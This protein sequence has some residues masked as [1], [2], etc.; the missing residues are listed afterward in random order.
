MLT[1]LKRWWG[2]ERVEKAA[3][4]STLTS[5]L[6]PG[7]N[8]T[9]YPSI[10]GNEAV[11]HNRG[12]VYGAVRVVAQ[13]IAAQPVRVGRLA[14]RSPVKGAKAAADSP[15]WV[16][17]GTVTELDEHPLIDSLADPNP[18]LTTWGLVYL[19]VAS[20]ELAGAAFWWIDEQPDGP[21]RVWYIPPGWVTEDPDSP[22]ALTRWLIRPAGLGE[23]FR[24]DHRELIRFALPDPG[25]PLAVLGPLQAAGAAA[26]TDESIQVAQLQ[27][28]KNGIMPGLLVR[29]GKTPELNGIGGDKPALTKEQ[30][31]SLRLALKRVNGGPPG[32]GEP[33]ILDAII[34][35]VEKLS[36]TPAEM[37]F[38][39]SGAVTKE[40]ILELFGV[41]AIVMGH[42]EGAN[43][44]TATVADEHVCYST[45]GPL[46]VLIGQTATKWFREHYSDPELVVWIDPPRPRDPDGRRADLD[47]LC[48]GGA[49]KK[50]ERRAEHGLPPLTPGEGGDD[51]VQVTGAGTTTAPKP[52]P[53][54]GGKWW[55]VLTPE[56]QQTVF[57]RTRGTVNGKAVK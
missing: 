44:A 37:D 52:D 46:C 16:R 53:G 50:N 35:G 42:I 22:E 54:D 43:R 28:F 51:L 32:A 3:R 9:A 24:L 57:L 45:C 48:R 38:Q 12:W 11:R 2:G 27:A 47:Q 14:G 1:W 10:D 7:A 39:D 41:N 4:S 34:E 30:R 15:P 8:G 33:L 20:L 5:F 26:L 49:I 36:L 25:N 19:A 21:T 31:D 55:D 40:R 56:E 18:Y 6:H 13:R 23:E 29:A 17:A